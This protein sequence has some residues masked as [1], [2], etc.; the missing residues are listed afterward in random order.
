MNQPLSDRITLQQAAQL[1][2]HLKAE[3]I[4]GWTENGLLAADEARTR[5]Y[6]KPHKIGGRVYTTEA[7]VLEYLAALE[8]SADPEVIRRLSR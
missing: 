8:P 2:P 5:I 3:T 4:R 1:H 7:E 6:L